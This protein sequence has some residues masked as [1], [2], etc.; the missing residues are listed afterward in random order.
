MTEVRRY[1]KETTGIPGEK[2]IE[3][4]LQRVPLGRM[5]DPDD[6]GRVV[7][8]LASAAADYM[9]GEMVVVDGGN[10]LT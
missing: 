9:C 1:I 6:I 10:L 7:L 8:F 2:V 4:F 5:G 3:E